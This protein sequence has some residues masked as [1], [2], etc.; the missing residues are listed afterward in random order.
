MADA[1]WVGDPPIRLTRYIR[2]SP[3][4]PQ[5]AFLYIDHILEALYGGAAGGGKSSA[6]LAAALQYVDVPGYSA[7]LLRRTFRDLGQPDALIPRSKEWLSGTDASWND[8]DH[9]WTFPSGATLTFGYLQH[10]D[11]KLQYQGAAFQFIGFDELTQFTETQYRYLFSRLRRPS[12]IAGGAPLS[13]VPLRMRSASNPG[14]PGH[15]WVKQR[16]GL[17]RR[18]EG[19]KSLPYVCHE[20]GWVEEH[21]RVFIPAKVDDNPHLDREEYDES[22]SELDPVTRA[23][24]RSGD[25][26]ATQPGDL[27]RR[28]WFDLCAQPPPG[29]SFV[30]F[31]DLA[32]TEPSSAN[33]D[34]DWTVGLKLGRTPAG[35]WV[36]AD[37][38][39]FRKRP[40]GVEG[41][42]QQ[43]AKVDGRGVP[44]WLEQEPGSSGKNTIAHYQ[45]TVLPGFEVRG[46]RSTGSKIERAGPVSSKAEAR[47]IEIV[48]ADWNLAFL[49]EV[50]AFPLGGHDD[51]VDALSGAFKQLSNAPGP[52]TGTKKHPWR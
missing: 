28:G 42:V 10:E 32:A 41:E 48:R 31:W 22:L 7:L 46:E 38:R 1:A 40:E 5:H 29:C 45:R 18:D 12:G 37:I 23:Q 51:Q 33:P 15:D 17:Y 34:P 27:F 14:G 25:W 30:R 11:D 8:N 52:A 39:R 13:Q 20:P 35:G 21:G 49:D 44:V 9:R 3:E 24:L 50:E 4:P 47:L 2:Q 43:A 6:L 36:V 26:D 19:D 16:F